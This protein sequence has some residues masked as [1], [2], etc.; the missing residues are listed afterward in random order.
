MTK[1][2]L[3]LCGGATAAQAPK[4]WRDSQEIILN[5]SGRDPNVNIRIEDVV[6]SFAKQVSPRLWDLL[7]IATYVYAA[8]TAAPRGKA[9]KRVRLSHGQGSYTL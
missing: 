1:P 5:A 6:R 8:D 2:R 3:L 7:E 4:S 9:G